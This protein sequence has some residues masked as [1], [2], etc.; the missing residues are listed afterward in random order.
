M[1]GLAT[2]ERDMEQSLRPLTPQYAQLGSCTRTVPATSPELLEQIRELEREISQNPPPI[3]TEHVFHAGM[4]ARTVRLVPGSLITGA[5]LQ[6][7]TMLI[8][9]G[10]ASMLV[11]EGWV[12]LEGYNVLPASAGRKQ[13]FFALSD[14]AI[15]M[16]F[17]TAAK[18]V[19]EVEEELTGEAD[20]LLS[21][22]EDNG[23]TITITGE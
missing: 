21:R 9:A 16:I 3:A 5:L 14:V 22:R 15:T 12:G 18:T 13:V 1:S 8:V 19:D 17:T 11:N 7:A 6:A 2:R 20:H 10:R 4:Y 23:D